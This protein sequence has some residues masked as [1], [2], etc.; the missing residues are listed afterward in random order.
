MS[1][2][3]DNLTEAEQDIKPLF[4]SIKQNLTY[5]CDAF[6]NTDD[7]KVR[8]I[9]V[10]RKSGI[11]IFLETMADSEKIEQNLLIPLAKSK[12]NED[13]DEIIGNVDLNMSNNL[14]DIITN[15]LSGNCTLLFED[16]KEAF[17]FNVAQENE[18]SPEEPDNEKIVRGSHLGFVES[19]DINLNLIRSRIVN[20]QLIVKYYELG[21]ESNT[22]IAL[23]YME[24][25][26]SPPL[27]DE[28]K[29]RIMSISMDAI[30]APGDIEETIETHPYS[31]FPQSLYTERPD[32][33][34]SHLMEGR[35]AIMVEG[36][37]DAIILPVTFFSFFHSPDDF[38]NR[39]YEGTAF[40]LLRLSSFWGSLILPALYIAMISFHF[41]II[42]FEIIPLVKNSIETVPFPPFFEALIM[43]VTIE[44]IR[45]AGIRLPSPIGETIGI[46]GGLIIGDAVVNAGL[47]SNMMVIVIALTAIMSF[48]IP[49]YTMSNTVRILT[50]PL[51][52]GA[53]TLGFV[54][55]VA[56]LMM[57]IIHM[58]KLESFGTPYLSP[59]VTFS[60]DDLKDTII[61]SPVWTMDKRPEN[62]NVEDSVRQYESREWDQ[63]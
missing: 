58:C 24:E 62:I 39:F 47:I 29:E 40:R 46:V 16:E 54:G 51:M 56:A 5:I 7:L 44:L 50:V 17:L 20:R 18:R 1:I 15:M 59:L 61:R 14:N 12:R 36:S 26:A 21:M 49:S 2:S 45:E 53:S 42:P 13:L 60:L 25:L 10:N 22:N 55:I 28:I 3:S 52:I 41:E 48:T 30:F 38:N 33:L 23:V 43:A 34:K 6:N 8:E 4:S 57:I 9:S 32:R 19:L 31:P 35:I 11:I 27:I 37:P 63:D